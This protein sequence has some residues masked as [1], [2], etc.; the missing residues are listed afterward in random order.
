[1]C[2]LSTNVYLVQATFSPRVVWTLL[3]VVFE[4]CNFPDS[5]VWYQ[6]YLVG[7]KHSVL[8][9]DEAFKQTQH[10]QA[11]TPPPKAPALN[12]SGENTKF[13]VRQEYKS[14]R[15]FLLR[16]SVKTPTGRPYWPL[17]LPPPSLVV[18]SVALPMLCSPKC[19][20]PYLEIP[21]LFWEISIYLVR[22]FR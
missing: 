17:L 2:D 21:W 11:K 10:R 16:K 12:F 4:E 6:V 9:R 22:S 7:D 18:G 3:I 1:M 19:T 20:Y 14:S 13:Y 8:L 5:E 15:S